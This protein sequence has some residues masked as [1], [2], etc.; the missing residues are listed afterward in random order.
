MV[1][2]LVVVVGHNKEQLLPFLQ[3]YNIITVFNE[4]YED[5]MFSSLMKGLESVR[6]ERM[7]MVPGDTPFFKK[8]TVRA[9]IDRQ[10][11]LI[12][13]SYK[14]RAGHPVLISGHILDD[15]R[16]SN[17]DNL[18]I[19]LGKYDKSY[20]VVDDEYILRDIDTKEVY[21]EIKRRIEH[22]NNRSC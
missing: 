5:G 22:E 18:R 11:N 19:F 13:P 7:L 9:L 12:V 20:L 3:Q 4:H 1:D 8:S 10:E 6:N 15:L 21:E 17:D 2:E 14:M 16:K